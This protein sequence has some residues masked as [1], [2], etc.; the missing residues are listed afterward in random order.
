MRP[1]ILPYTAFKIVEETEEV[2]AALKHKLDIRRVPPPVKRADRK[3]G[4]AQ[5]TADDSE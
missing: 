3:S 5:G 4:R 1:P 2:V